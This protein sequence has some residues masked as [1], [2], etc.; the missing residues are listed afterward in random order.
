M[1]A[2][3]K[4]RQG[5]FTLVEVI[6]ALVIGAIAAAMVYNYFSASLTSSAEPIKRLQEA[7]NLQRVMEN[8]IADFNRL[9]ALNLRYKW[10][11][12]ISY[13]VGYVVVPPTS[14]GHF[15]TCTVAGTSVAEP[16]WPTTAGATVSDGGALWREGG[17]ILNAT[18]TAETIVWQ[19]TYSYAI[20]DIMIPVANDGHYYRCTN[21]GLT[22]ASVPA[23]WKITTGYSLNDVVFP[24]SYNGHYY[25]CTTAGTSGA[26]EPSWPVSGTVNDGTVVWTEAWA[27]AGTILYST[28]TSNTVLKDNLYNYLTNNPGRYDHNSNSY[29]VVAAETRF[30][31]F[32]GSNEVAAGTNGASS[33]KNILKV[34]IKDSNSARTLTEIFTIR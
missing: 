3:M 8:I 34:T 29:A 23:K 25:K 14:N 15:Y 21:A 19:S 4:K 9:N 22:G 12:G 28:D 7:N 24:T 11:S 32:S 33:E 13:R 2:L 6:A 10:R 30:I 20:N 18:G 31:Q 5:G 17:V 26:T 1:K 16:A 27:E